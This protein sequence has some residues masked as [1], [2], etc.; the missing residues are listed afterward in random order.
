MSRRVWKDPKLWIGVLLSTFFVWLALRGLE[1]GRI[2]LALRGADYRV[3]PPAVALTILVIWIRSARW[4]ILLRGLKEVRVGSLFRAT[5]IGFTVNYLL[6]ARVGEVVRAYVLGMHEGVSSSAAFATVVVERLLDVFSILVVFVGVMLFVRIPEE[7]PQ[8][9][10]TLQATAAVMAIVAASGVVFLWVVRRRTQSLKTFL[11]RSVGRISPRAGDVLSRLME[12]FSSGVAP[13]HRIRDIIEISIYTAFLWITTA[14]GVILIAEGLRLGLPW[15]AAW[16][17]LVAL[18]FG[19]SVPSAPG[20]VGTFH[21]SAMAC[22]LL[23]GVPRPEA[24]SYA[25]LLHATNILPVLFLGLTL[26][27]REGLTLGGL[28]RMGARVQA[29][30]QDDRAGRPD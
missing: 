30:G 23:Y 27:W 10:R 6:P 8:L 19:V 5:A 4:K 11:G 22:L 28:A 24:L 9:V 3:L 15:E 1:P 13:V 16:L 7:N 2:L 29:T 25:I 14:A 12:S 20:F 18:A 17:I 21:Y 26:L